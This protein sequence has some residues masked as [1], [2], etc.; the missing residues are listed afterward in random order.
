MPR[1]TIKEPLAPNAQ[2]ADVPVASS[3]DLELDPDM[4]MDTLLAAGAT[5]GEALG[6]I[7]AID[8]EAAMTL[9]C[10][11]WDAF[12]QCGKKLD[13][14]GQEWITQLPGNGF[15]PEFSEI[16]L[17]G[18]VNFTHFGQGFYI[19]DMARVRLDGTQWD[20]DC[21]DMHK[22]AK[23]HFNGNTWFRFRSS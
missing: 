9:L 17:T 16:D 11:R 8:P 19:Y 10:E 1:R 23:I 3:M 21:P 14:R 2:V 6:Q 4:M 18:C 22:D 20:E 7:G 12:V 5:H 15:M 13:L